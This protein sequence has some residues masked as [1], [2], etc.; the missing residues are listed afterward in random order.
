MNSMEAFMQTIAVRID[1][2]SPKELRDAFPTRLRELAGGLIARHTAEVLQGSD[3]ILFTLDVADASLAIEIVVNLIEQ[4][5]ILGHDL[6]R[7]ST[8]AVKRGTQYEV[9]FPSGVV[10]AFP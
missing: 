10:E 4:E 2:R 6:R 5:R 9:V 8:I 7:G 3:A 1:S